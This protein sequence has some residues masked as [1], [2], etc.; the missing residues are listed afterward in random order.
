MGYRRA[1]KTRAKYNRVE[2][3]RIELSR[4]VKRVHYSVLRASIVRC[5][6]VF[7]SFFIFLSILL[8]ND[9]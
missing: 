9:V 2:K 7:K 6:L 8:S 3:S 4:A 5:F 1:E